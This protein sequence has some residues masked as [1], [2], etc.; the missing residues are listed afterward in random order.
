MTDPR[1]SIT[2]LD[3][4]RRASELLLAADEELVS[5]Q[6]LYGATEKTIELKIRLAE[7]FLHYSEKRLT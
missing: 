1:D 2:R 4:S 5:L 6:S 7:A 3:A